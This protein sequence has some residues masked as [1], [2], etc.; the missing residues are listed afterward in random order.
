MENKNL[1]LTEEQCK[2]R[3]LGEENNRKARGEMHEKS[4]PTAEQ[5]L[6]ETPI[7]FSELEDANE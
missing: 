5:L 7:S 1:C 2:I 4:L 6:G 3:A